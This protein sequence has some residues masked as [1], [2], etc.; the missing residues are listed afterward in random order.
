MGSKMLRAAMSSIRP[1]TSSQYFVALLASTPA[2]CD[3]RMKIPQKCR[4]KIPLLGSAI[5]R[6]TAWAAPFFRG[7]PRRLGAGGGVMAACERVCSGMQRASRSTI[8]SLRS[9]SASTSTPAS[10]VNHPPSKARCTGLPETGDRPGRK[11]AFSAM[12]GASSV[13]SRR[14]GFS[15]RNLHGLKSLCRARQPQNRR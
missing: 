8:R 11:G 10:E 1:T 2:I 13:R 14:I 15:N 5:S 6:V 12:V 7:L 3:C 9:I 4:T